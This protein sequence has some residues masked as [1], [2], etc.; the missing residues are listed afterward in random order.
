MNLGN[1]YKNDTNLTELTRLNDL[2]PKDPIG[3]F[4]NEEDCFVVFD[5][6]FR[7]LISDLHHFLVEKGKGFDVESNDVIIE[8]FNEPI[9]NK[10]MIVVMLVDRCCCLFKILRQE[11]M[12][13]IIKKMGREVKKSLFPFR[14]IPLRNLKIYLIT[15][16]IIVHY[17]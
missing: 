7:P 6:L 5:K 4:A 11:W 17:S 2:F 16:I 10:E 9:I 3:I 15:L 13:H 14:F 1:L 12:A 8:G